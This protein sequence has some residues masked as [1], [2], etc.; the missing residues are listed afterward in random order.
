MMKPFR[1]H[2]TD[3][4]LLLLAVI[5]FLLVLLLPL[6]FAVADELSKEEQLLLTAFENGEI[7]RLHVI[8]HS[9]SA[10]DQQIKYAVRDALIEQF[11]EILS[12]CGSDHETAYRLLHES[13][14]EMEHTARQTAA[15]MGFQGEVNAEVGWL[16]LPQK[17]YGNV[18]LP[19][20]RY[21]A[22]RIVLGSGEGENWWCVLYP[23]LCLALS[24]D[25]PQNSA[26]VWDSA[27]IWANWIPFAK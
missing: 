20:G 3:S 7:I 16:E 13:I 26:I 1:N 4:M 12:A 11:G 27:R 8:A 6:A 14:T 2:W 23:Q 18:M 21:R 10:R 15:A 17:R 9:N 22:M 5:L 19:S 24:E 25:E